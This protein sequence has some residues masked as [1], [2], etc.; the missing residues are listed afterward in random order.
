[1]GNIIKRVCGNDAGIED[2]MNHP[3][4]S[5][6]DRSSKLSMT[7]MTNPSTNKIWKNMSIEVHKDFNAFAETDHF[8]DESD[9]KSCCERTA[10]IINCE[11]DLYSK[12]VNLDHF[13]ILKVVGRGSFGKVFLVQK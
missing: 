11:Q 4:G 10:S 1:M 8:D 9:N 5:G 7:G 6:W 12:K 3:R 2:V 13:E